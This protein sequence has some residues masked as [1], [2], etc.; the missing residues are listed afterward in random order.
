MAALPSESEREEQPRRPGQ[1]RR[2]NAACRESRADH[3][4][5]RRRWKRGIRLCGKTYAVM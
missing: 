2:Q 5:V 4:P 1:R 3:Q